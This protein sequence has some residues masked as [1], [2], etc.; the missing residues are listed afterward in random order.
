MRV[1]VHGSPCD[2]RSDPKTDRSFHRRIIVSDSTERQDAEA[3]L[4]EHGLSAAEIAAQT[5]IVE[6][7]DAYINDCI[8]DAMAAGKA[9]RAGDWAHVEHHA[10]ELARRRATLA[11]P[12][13]GVIVERLLAQMAQLVLECECHKKHADA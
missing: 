3:F 6:Q 7:A 1:G 5:A 9:A 11:M 2:V 8:P 4:A 13:A 12:M 10:S